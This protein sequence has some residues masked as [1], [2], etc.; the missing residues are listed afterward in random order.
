MHPP[1]LRAHLEAEPFTLAMSSG[2]FGFFAHAGFARALDEEGLAPAS[3][4]GA[5]AGALVGSFLAAGLGTAEIAGLLFGL[6]RAQF[7]DPAPGVGLLRGQR[8]RQLLADHL[9]ARSFEDCRIPLTLSVFDTFAG[10]TRVLDRGPLVPAVY[11]SCCVPLLF[12]PQF[13]G[14][15]PLYDGG[16]LDR[17]G[18][19][20]VPRG[21]RVFYHHLASRSPWRR[22]GSRSLLVPRREGLTALVL[23]GLP[24]VGPFR[25]GE[26]QRAYALARE[27]TLRALDMPLSTDVIELTVSPSAS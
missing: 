2:F 7:W 23:Q 24:R 16:I 10:R 17:A 20:G 19:A 15:R 1:T 12:Q 5:S 13:H 25:L 18:L 3:A 6:E 27:A 9:P 4:A 22:P 11:A 21:R 8:F 14:R 26:G